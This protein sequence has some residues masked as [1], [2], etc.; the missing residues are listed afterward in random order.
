MSD[1]FEYKYSAPSLSERQQIDSIRNQYLPK[2]KKEEKLEKLKKLD[3]KVKEIP[4]I[5][6]LSFG[7][8]GTLI[9]G[10]AMTFF[11]EWTNYFIVGIPFALIGGCLI[12]IA[13]PIYKKSLEKLKNKYGPEIIKLSNELLDEESN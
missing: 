4:M 5:T 8:V 11:L 7:I 9:F 13:Y 1:K 10:L 2:D 6:S 3:N 12:A